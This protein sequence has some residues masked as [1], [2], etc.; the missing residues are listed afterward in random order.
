[1]HVAD[2]NVAEGTTL[3]ERSAS[4]YPLQACS[5]SSSDLVAPQKLTGPLSSDFGGQLHWLFG[6]GPQGL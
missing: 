2:F 5:P 6:G 3:K 1:M 4:F